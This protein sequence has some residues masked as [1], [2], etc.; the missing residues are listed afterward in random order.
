MHRIDG[1]GHVGNTFVEGDPLIPQEATIVTAAWT[2]AVQEEIAN[3]VEDNGL[4]LDKAD[5][6]QLLQ[7]IGGGRFFKNQLKS[8]RPIRRF[9][10]C[11]ESTSDIKGTDASRC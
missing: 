7:S 10:N 2:N 8:N 1:P 5:N 3:V 9:A 4:V 6:T 11:F